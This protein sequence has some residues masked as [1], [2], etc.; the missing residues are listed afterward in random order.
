MQSCW[1]CP[2]NL[3]IFYYV[4]DGNNSN[5]SWFWVFPH[6]KFSGLFKKYGTSIKKECS[7]F[8]QKEFMLHSVMFSTI[9]VG[10]E[11]FNIIT[12]SIRN[13]MNMTYVILVICHAL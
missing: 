4:V 8:G 3:S 6:F 13:N 7:R 11:L 12:S 5:Q 10:R 2:D 1:T 9:D